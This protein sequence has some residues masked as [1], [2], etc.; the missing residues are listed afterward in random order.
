[1]DFNIQEIQDNLLQSKALKVGIPVVLTAPVTIPI[2]Q[3]LA[4]IAVAGLT[5]FAAGS[6]IG[7]S[8]SVLSDMIP[9]QR[10]QDDSPTL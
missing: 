7:K 6:L 9:Q 8:S 1:M 3:G 10:E 2:L 4:G 5:L